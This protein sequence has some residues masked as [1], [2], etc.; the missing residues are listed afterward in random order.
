[1]NEKRE[2]LLH[3]LRILQKKEEELALMIQAVDANFL[4]LGYKV[5]STVDV[6]KKPIPVQT[7]IRIQGMLSF[8]GKDKAAEY[9]DVIDADHDGFLNY[10]DFRGEVIIMYFRTISIVQLL[11]NHRNRISAIRGFH[12]HL[13]YVNAPEVQSRYVFVPLISSARFTSIACT[14]KPGV[15]IWLTVDSQLRSLGE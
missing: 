11:F 14:V 8:R 7:G 12:D 3:T 9:F 2:D 5:D 4:E 6:T 1:M 15:C 10:E 13:G